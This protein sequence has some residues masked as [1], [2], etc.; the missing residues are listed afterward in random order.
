MIACEN[1]LAIR[2]PADLF[3]WQDRDA[4]L[5][6][7]SIGIGDDP[8]DPAALRFIHERGLRTVP[9]FATVA[10]WGS[11]PPLRDAGVDY[12]KVVHAAQE[13]VVHRLLPPAGRVRADG[14]IVSVVD[15]GD[16]GALV[17]A[18]V[19]LRDADSGEAYVTNRVTWLARA[20]GNFG[21]PRDGG[22]SP[23]PIPDRAPDRTITYSTRP[24]QAALYR[25]LGDRNPLHID[26]AIAAHAGFDRPILHGLC[27]F[28][29]T[30]RAVM[31]GFAG[32]EPERIASHA[33]R[34]SSPVLPG[35]DIAV[36]MWRDGATISFEARVPA[37]G[38]TVIRNGRAQL[39]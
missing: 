3:A 37:R 36:D 19:V 2:S 15:K 31:E 4:M 32:M 18:H 9:T 23:H 28:G 11:N 12:T 5:Y 6:A 34:F 35:D 14:G 24:D 39:R 1:V 27:T 10:A 22:S 21:G 38:V 7:L 30:C 17:E 26:P 29:I 20:D 25:L 8:L 13:V 33:A 16:K